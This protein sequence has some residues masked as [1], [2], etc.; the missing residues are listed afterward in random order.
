MAEP[1]NDPG[2]R[3]PDTRGVPD[4]A[5]PPMQLLQLATEV[6]NDLG[7]VEFLNK[8]EQT[9]YERLKEAHE[10]ANK[11]DETSGGGGDIQFMSAVLPITNGIIHIASD[12]QRIK[13]ALGRLKDQEATD[14]IASLSALTLIY[15][16]TDGWTDHKGRAT[17]KEQW[18]H[19]MER[20]KRT[21]A[22]RSPK[23]RA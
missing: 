14:P 3:L 2:G 9:L 16:V 21:A 17:E 8:H 19:I 5:R 22:G 1:A 18:L 23:A 4:E 13:S 15:F 11:V 6:V 12:R 20:V 10:Y 7:V